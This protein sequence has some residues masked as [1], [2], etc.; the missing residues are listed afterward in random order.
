MVKLNSDFN[1]NPHFPFT[2]GDN[3]ENDGERLSDSIVY[4]LKNK[5][6]QAYLGYVALDWL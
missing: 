1:E 6:V 3:V 5:Q 4:K 2:Y